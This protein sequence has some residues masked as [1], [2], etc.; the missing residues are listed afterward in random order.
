M[1]PMNIEEV[2]DE[3]DLNVSGGN[4]LAGLTIPLFVLGLG[5]LSLF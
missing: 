1:E 2:E 3:E 4:S 5:V